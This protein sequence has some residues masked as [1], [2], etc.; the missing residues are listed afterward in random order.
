M[1][2]VKIFLIF[3]FVLTSCA[4]NDSYKPAKLDAESLKSPVSNNANEI[5]SAG[6]KANIAPNIKT[7]NHDK[8]AYP[9]GGS[10]APVSEPI[11][12][13][14]SG[15][16]QL[17]EIGLPFFTGSLSGGG[18]RK[19]RKKRPITYVTFG[20]S[21]SDPGNNF[22][23]FGEVS[24]PPFQPVPDFPYDVNGHRFTNG[25]VWIEFLAKDRKSNGPAYLKPGIFTNYAVGRARA[26]T[27]SIVF[28]DYNLTDQVNQF[29]EDYDQ[30]VFP[31]ARY[32]IWIGANDISDALTALAVDQTGATSQSIIQQAV[33]AIVTN[34]QTLA[35]KGARFIYV[36]NLPDIGKTPAIQFL[37]PPTTDFATQ[38]SIAFNEGLS[39]AITALNAD[40]N[41]NTFINLIDFFNEVL[42]DDVLNTT[43]PCLTFFV[44]ENAFCDD[45][46]KR[47]LWDAFH[48]TT[49]GHRLIWKFVERQ[50]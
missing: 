32:M 15:P 33:A 2:I 20:D 41:P 38:F 46:D 17:G 44:V 36:L 11:A 3:S 43:D 31:N 21:L 45:P 13:P 25:P 35:S 6:H 14:L 49:E 42:G 47:F 9:L 7:P 12:V 8:Y 37:G 23:I 50:L 10:G 34:I 27:G 24:L 18:G 30:E 28:P 26:R 19:I 16:P 1:T 22:A 4:C 29:L 39:A 40:L 48:P 5:S